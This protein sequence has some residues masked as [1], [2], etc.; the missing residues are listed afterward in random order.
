M[1]VTRYDCE[2]F[3]LLNYSPELSYEALYAVEQKFIG[4]MQQALDAIAAEHLDFWGSGDVL[5][6]QCALARFDR[7]TLHSLCDEAASCLVEQTQAKIVCIDKHLTRIGVYH[8]APGSW[9]EEE[10]DIAEPASS[11][12]APHPRAGDSSPSEQ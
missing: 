11:S 4:H 2:L 7:P 9:R 8:L 3:G 6:F 5:Q 1:S 10:L 12:A